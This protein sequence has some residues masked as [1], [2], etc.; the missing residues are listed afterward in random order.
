MNRKSSALFDE[1]IFELISFVDFFLQI[2]VH[3]LITEG[4]TEG[5]FDILLYLEDIHAN[6]LGPVL[7][8]NLSIKSY[9]MRI[10]KFPSLEI[11]VC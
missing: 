2:I 8:T 4:S 3:G 6:V 10:S 1:D 5:I 11:W 9:L 7:G